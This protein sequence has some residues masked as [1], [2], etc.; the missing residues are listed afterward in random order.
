VGSFHTNIVLQQRADPSHRPC[1][2]HAVSL[3]CC[4]AEDLDFHSA[5]VFDS[6]I[7][8]HANAAPL[9]SSDHAPLKVTSQGHGTE[10]AGNG[11]G[12]VN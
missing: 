7:P 11:M 1:C 3:P 6:H 12:C 8:Y 4:V 2:A 9:L 10:T 5:S